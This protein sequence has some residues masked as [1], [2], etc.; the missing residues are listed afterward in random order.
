LSV[1][2]RWAAKRLRDPMR[3]IA[4]LL[5]LRSAAKHL[6]APLR[7]LG[8]LV[9]PGRNR[10]LGFWW[11]V[12]T[13]GIAVALG[14]VVALLLTPLAGLVAFLVAASW[15]LARRRRHTPHRSPLPAACS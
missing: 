14:M 2:V 10:G 15:S 6:P 11:V 13:I 9:D 1:L 8:G 3:P 12:A 7:W 5:M 4:R